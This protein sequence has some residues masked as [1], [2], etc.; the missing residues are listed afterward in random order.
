MK[1]PRRGFPHRK[2][3]S[4]DLRTQKNPARFPARGMKNRSRA[5]PRSG[6]KKTDLGQARDRLTLREFQFPEYT[7]P[8]IRASAF[9]PKTRPGSRAVV[10]P[11]ARQVRRS[12]EAVKNCSVRGFPF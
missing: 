10:T 12:G 7:I 8:V 1:K 11:A 6:H 5:S 9:Q 2:S 4:P 3:G